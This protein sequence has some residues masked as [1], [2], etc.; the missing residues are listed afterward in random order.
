[1]FA[2]KNKT[3]AVND[4]TTGTIIGEGVI[5]EGG[6]IKGDGNVRIDGRYAGTIDL[7]GHIVVGETGVVEGEIKAFSAL[8]AGKFMGNMKIEDTVHL[9]YRSNV[10]GNIECGKVIMDEDSIFNGNC[11]M[12]RELDRSDLQYTSDE[13]SL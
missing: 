10:N 11:K 3:V 9:A 7:N 5:F 2:K 12:S 8:F 6:V 4:K 1:M 13:E